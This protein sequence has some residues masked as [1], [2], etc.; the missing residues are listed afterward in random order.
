[1]YNLYLTFKKYYG[2]IIYIIK[3]NIKTNQ[4]NG[5]LRCKIKLNED[6]GGLRCK[7]KL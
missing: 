7:I 3:N 6:N 4:D 1:M 5:G 2:I